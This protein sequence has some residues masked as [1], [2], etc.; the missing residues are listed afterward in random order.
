MS[1]ISQ[2]FNANSAIRLYDSDWRCVSYLVNDMTIAGRALG[3]VLLFGLTRSD[4]L[5]NCSF[6]RSDR[7]SMVFFYHGQTGRNGSVENDPP[8]QPTVPPSPT[9]ALFFYYYGR[10]T[11]KP[12]TE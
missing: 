7:G 1:T 2:T 10:S 3:P 5:N 6:M 8:N 4:R 11:G 12:T 9:I